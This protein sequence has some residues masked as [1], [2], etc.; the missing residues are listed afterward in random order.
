[1]KH[2]LFV[3]LAT[4]T[5]AQQ[6]NTTADRKR[7]V[8]NGLLTHVPVRGLKPWTLAERMRYHRVP[9]VSIAVIRNYKIDWMQ[10]YGL[11]DTTTR[12]PVTN[13]TM[14]SCGSISKLVAAMAA[15]TLVDRGKMALD[16]PINTYLTS[17]KLGENDFTRQTPVTLGML[18][19]HRGGTSQ[20][21]YFGYAPS[22]SPMPTVLE[23]L[24][25]DVKAESRRVGVVSEPGKTF[26]Y[27]G[28]GTLVAQQAV[29]DVVGQEYTTFTN[30]TLF[31]KLGLTRITFAQPLPKQYEPYAAWA[32]S[33]N[34]WFKGMPYVYPQQAVA[35]L[36][37]NAEG[38][39]RILIDLQNSLRGKGNIL[40]Q[41]TAREMVR[42]RA[43]V[44]EG[45]YKEEIG[46][47]PFLFQRADN[48]RPDG[49]YFE[50]MGL[51]AGFTS[52][53]MSSV[54]GGNGVVILM[55]AN[56]GAN[57]LGKEI[58]RAV[59]NVYGWVNFLPDEIIPRNVPGSELDRYVGR[60]QRGPDEV[61][62]IERRDT[63]PE[64]TFLIERINGGDPIPC[65]FVGRDTIAFT[66]F[67]AKAFFSRNAA[68]QVDSLRTE[69]QQKPMPRLA[70]DKLLPNELLR[71]GRPEA[72]AAYR[73]LGQNLYELTYLA[74]E[75]I[76]APRPNLKAAATLLT[77]ADERFPNKAIVQARWG[78][79][80][81]KQGDRAKAI[82][83]YEAAL[84]LDPSDTDS[85]EYLAQLR[86]Q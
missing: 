56:N 78:D 5:F 51:N 45:Y 75:Y 38:I 69:F 72:L 54:E 16:T 23:I 60:Y 50:H 66:D 12:R 73:E 49:V 62:S 30:N 46:M 28:G 26:S 7:L 58:R 67:P 25:G 59:A 9:G 63:Y 17:W 13:E 48:R 64:R 10:G 85:K 74:Y 76:Y 55:N 6:P 24:S 4:A 37:S 27:S 57:E 34:G 32:Y 83:A 21:S 33:E 19:S 61:V 40:S 84:R 20:A 31:R 3:L 36:Y 70:N 71:A 15:M 65:F 52:Y 42:P 82:A 2:L 41:R 11:A 68:G 77:L 53:A 43:S 18:L 80:Y 47:G 1:M 44:S 39:A 14:F 86:R 35:G 8:E 29:T 79:L 81:R 22:K